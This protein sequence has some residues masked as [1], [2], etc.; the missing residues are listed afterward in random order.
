[1]GL[2][3]A[4]LLW[5]TGI[6]EAHSQ[7]TLSRQFHA[8]E[9]QARRTGQIPA[10][11][12]VPGYAIGIIKIP[13]IHLEKYIVQGTGES[14]LQKGPG[15]Y[16]STPMPGQPGNVGIAGH[17]TTY[18][19]PFYNISELHK[20]DPIEITM[21]SG[22]T[23]TYLVACPPGDAGGACVDG[24]QVVQPTDVAVVGPTKDN[25][26]TLTTCNPRFSASTRLV[27]TALL[28]GAARPAPVI[29]TAQARPVPRPT[30]LSLGQAR[31]I[32][33]IIL[34]GLAG[35]AAWF[36]T[37]A[38]ARRLGWA[39]WIPGVVGVLVLVYFFFENTARI[40]PANF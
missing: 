24:Q 20:G 28:E 3:V 6:T 39:L 32:P 4:Y 18:G 11:A 40:L 33:W 12:A 2:F 14:D 21:P 1:M 29:Q 13:K 19:A 35:V 27:V 7:S 8:E 36:L 30:S 37:W 38:L 10:Q 17:R 25:Q 16:P 15:H 34:Y 5:G 9:T 23:Y 22:V 31:A 26:L